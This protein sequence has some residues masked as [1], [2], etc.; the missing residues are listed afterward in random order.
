[1]TTTPALDRLIEA[2]DAAT[3]RRR[4]APHRKK[5]ARA[6]RT[7]FR[8]QLRAVLRAM[9]RHRSALFREAAGEIPL[10]WL[11]A[12]LT[13]SSRWITEAIQRAL[14]PA[15]MAGARAVLG[16]IRDA[17]DLQNPRAVEFMREALNRSSRI[18]DETF[19]QIRDILTA[20]VRDGRSYGEMARALREKWRQFAAPV[21]QRHLR[22]RAG[23]IAVTEIGNAYSAGTMMAAEALAA[24][25]FRME[26]SWLTVGDERVEPECSGNEAE[27]WI[28]L[29]TEFSS[30][31][32]RPLAHPGCRCALLTR[33]AL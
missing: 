22:D 13:L 17:F 19:R 11:A 2:A 7:A 24:R 5:L 27:G 25:G 32:Q 3:Y 8:K 15:L 28:P 30:G 31:D 33:V 4:Q 14:P 29:D 18:T 9:E 1:M 26:K 16:R 12:A 6:L 20:G 23:L 10:D 21:P